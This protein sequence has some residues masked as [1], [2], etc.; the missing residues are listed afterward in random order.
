MSQQHNIDTA[1][2]AV[3]IMDFQ[4]EIVSNNAADPTAVVNKARQVLDKARNIGIPVI[5]V[6]HRGGRFEAP[7]EA[8]EIHPT[9]IPV[10][11]ERVL[12]KTKAGPFSTTGLDIILRELGVNT[13][14]FMGVS[15]SG[16]VLS[17]TR[18][19][20]DL[21][22]RVLVVKDACDDRDPEVHRVLT[23]KIFSFYMQNLMKMRSSIYAPI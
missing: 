2:T 8:A 15:T 3:I 5:H 1:K 12:S 6:I 20:N 9:V 19:A 18:W 22:Y 14:V 16:C 11:G 7:S 4:N 10:E 17:G 13:L 23:E 21:N